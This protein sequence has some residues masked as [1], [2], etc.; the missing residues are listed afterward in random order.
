[1]C[2]ELGK[3]ASS[4]VVKCLFI[5]ANVWWRYAQYFLIASCGSVSRGNICV[6]MAHVYLYV[7]CSDCVNVCCVVGVFYL[8][9]EA[10]SCR[11]SCMESMS[12]SSYRCCMFGLVFILRQSSML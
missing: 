6:Y 11:C 3:C 4:E 10:W 9:C 8:N 7:C 12:V 2:S 1:M 5:P